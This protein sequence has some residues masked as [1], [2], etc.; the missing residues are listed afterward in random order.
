MRKN[1][2]STQLQST[3][4]SAGNLHANST[5]HTERNYEIIDPKIPIVLLYFVR[6][7]LKFLLSYLFISLWLFSQGRTRSVYRFKVQLNQSAIRL[8]EYSN[9]HV[10]RYGDEC[11]IFTVGVHFLFHWYLVK[12]RKVKSSSYIIKI[13][14]P[15]NYP[16]LSQVTAIKH[17]DQSS[18][19]YVPH[20]R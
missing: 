16:Y 4:K 10:K 3:N 5:P 13:V 6:C 2:N 20:Q 19:T 11:S 9:S 8:F 17:A 12:S 7:L 15:F 1:K 18:E 14:F